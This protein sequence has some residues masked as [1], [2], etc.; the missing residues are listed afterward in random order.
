MDMVP[1]NR[2]A[3]PWRY[4]LS[5][6]GVFGVPVFF[7]LSA[8]LITE[9][10]MR[11]RERTSTIHWRSFYARRILRIWP[12]YFAAFFG[13]VALGRLI[14]RVGAATPGSWLAFTFFSGNWYICKYGWLRAYPTNPLWSIS[15]EEQ[16]YITIPFAALY[17]QRRGLM[18]LCAG[19]IAVAYATLYFYAQKH[20][21]HGY[22]QWTNSLVQFQFFAAGMLLSLVFRGRLPAMRLLLR[23]GAVAGAISC[24]LIAFIGFG[25]EA[26]RPHPTSTAGFLF[27]WVLVLAG[28]VLVFLSLLGVSSRYLPRAAIY[29]GRI[30]YGLYIFHALALF[31]VFRIG[32]EWTSALSAA[33]HLAAW[34][35]AVGTIVALILT[36]LVAT[37]SYEFFE[38]PFLRL[39]KRFTFVPSRD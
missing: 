24:W 12:L 21:L 10:L 14:P 4:G 35:D 30:S 25:V 11:E 13:L 16:F 28:T 31:M 34:R 38:K 37:L 29:L 19:I 23:L 1:I 36:L 7:L 8:F 39:K 3:H 32:K 22:S 18:A 26:D 27:G 33:L 17:L 20:P 5:L 2:L 15:I 9:L 6:I